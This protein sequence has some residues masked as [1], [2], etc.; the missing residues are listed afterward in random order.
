MTRIIIQHEP[1][2]PLET[3]F[4]HILAARHSEERVVVFMDHIGV[5]KTPVEYFVRRVE[6]ATN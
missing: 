3:V 6:P 4:S 5:F 2:I 1:D